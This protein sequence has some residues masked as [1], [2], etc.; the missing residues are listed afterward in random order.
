MTEQ[1]TEPKQMKPLLYVAFFSAIGVLTGIIFLLFYYGTQYDSPVS[2]AVR[3][4]S[5]FGLTIIVLLV[6]FGITFY[7][8]IRDFLHEHFG[9]DTADEIE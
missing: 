6:V 3:I 4:R 9:D 5:A 1:T 2:E 7:R 8:N